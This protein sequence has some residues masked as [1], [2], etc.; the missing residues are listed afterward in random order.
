VTDI[1]TP[2]TVAVM[3][4][5]AQIADLGVIFASASSSRGAGWTFG[6]LPFAHVV[7][8]AGALRRADPDRSDYYLDP[9]ILLTLMRWRPRAV[10]CAGW[11]FPTWYA[12]LYCRLSGAALIV[13]SDGT[14][15]TERAL[16][17]P[18]RL[19]RRLLVRRCQA[20]AANSQAARRRFLELG[21][22]P[23]RVRSAPHSTNLAPFWEAAARRRAPAPGELRVL[24]AGRLVA[25]KGFHHALHAVARAQARA[26]GISLRIVGRGPEEASLRELASELGLRRV[27]FSGFVEQPQLAEC[28]AHSDAFLFCSLQDEFGLV[29]LEAQAAGLACVA[30]PLA[31]ATED[32]IVAGRNGLIADPRDPERLSEALLL[33]L[34]DPDL[35]ATLGRNAHLDSLARTPR[36]TAEGY[37]EAVGVARE[38][39]GGRSR[40]AIQ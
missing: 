34:G 30:S 28:C 24:V 2:Y 31:G 14:S 12:A 20:F 18:Q 37:L 6:E 11:S 36:R 13:H 10:I 4:E 29:L 27:Q 3:G 39:A 17:R 22:P 32:L 8:G 7:L 16:S 26:P 21:A 5:L 23:A 1:I 9:R 15:R 33:L 19:S 38:A 40:P 25:R 35:R